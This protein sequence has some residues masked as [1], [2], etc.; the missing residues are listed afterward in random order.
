[1]NSFQISDTKQIFLSSTENANVIKKNSTYNSKIDF[2]LPRLVNR[3]NKNILYNT[4]KLTHAEIPYSFYTI[5]E[6]N[7]KLYYKNLNTNETFIKTIP[8]GNYNGNTLITAIVNLFLPTAVSLTLDNSTGVFTFSSSIQFQFLTGANS[9]NKILG[10]G[11][12]M[13]Y[14]TQ[15]NNGQYSLVFPYSLNILGSKCIFV[16]ATNLV[17]ENLNTK[18]QDRST[19]KSIPINV[20]PFG[21]IMYNNIENIE[22]IIKNK[23][24]DNLEIELLDDDNNLINF[25]NQEWSITLE[26]KSVV[27]VNQSYLNINEYLARATLADP[28]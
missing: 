4:I 14:I 22:T 28:E 7:N 9:I 21:L 13:N 26:I 2:K 16:K 17:L 19:I 24:V 20:S 5:N 8:K 23:Q 15:F 25:E 18:T 11:Q 1:M 3:Y 10:L 6:S 27:L 12:N